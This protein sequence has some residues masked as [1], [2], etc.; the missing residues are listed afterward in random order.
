MARK[1]EINDIDYK[2]LLYYTSLMRLKYNLE[3]TDAKPA[4]GNYEI[5][6]EAIDK[7]KLEPEIT[8]NKIKEKNPEIYEQLHIQS[9]K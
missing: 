2:R 6:L 5:I 4:P 8:L 9:K 7:L 1:A 3:A